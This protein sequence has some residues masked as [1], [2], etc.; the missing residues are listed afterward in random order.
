MSPLI[1][2]AL[3]VVM[4]TLA[5]FVACFFLLMRRMWLAAEAIKN[6]EYGRA[7]HLLGER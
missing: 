5:L 4:V 7:L 1:E 2:A 6:R 3:P